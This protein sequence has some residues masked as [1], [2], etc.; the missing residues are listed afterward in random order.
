MSHGRRVVVCV[1]L[2][3]AL[4]VA[5]RAVTRLITEVDGGW[6]MYAPDSS[7]P[8]SSSDGDTVTCALIWLAAIGVW[9]V[10]SWR[11]FGPRSD[12]G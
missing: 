6:F 9:A 7:A 3:L 10:V 5:A 11:L 4:V 2:G 8:F 12:K 1:A